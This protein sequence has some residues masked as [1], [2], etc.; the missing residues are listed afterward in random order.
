MQHPPLSLPPYEARGHRVRHE[1]TEHKGR[2]RTNTPK[3]GRVVPPCNM[4]PS[5]LRYCCWKTNCLRERE[6][7]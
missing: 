2:P 4:A 5:Q 1:A 3:E 6:K 7:E